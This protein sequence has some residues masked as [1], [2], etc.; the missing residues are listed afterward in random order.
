MKYESDFYLNKSY[1]KSTMRHCKK[2]EVDRVM[3]Y[4]KS[5]KRIDMKYE[6]NIEN[7]NTLQSKKWG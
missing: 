7:I 4:R 3:S 5:K 6:L 2:C 1:L